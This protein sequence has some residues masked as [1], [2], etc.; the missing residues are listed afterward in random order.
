MR[1]PSGVAGFDDLI[2]GGLPAGRLYVL[3]GPPGSGK[4]TFSSQFLVEGVRQG[5]NC[6]LVSMHESRGDIVEDM[7]GYDFGFEQAI[8][9]DRMHFVDVF[10]NE[11]KQ[12]FRLPGNRRGGNDVVN[13]LT[14]FIESKNI[15][16]VVIDSTM[17]LEYF[18]DDTENS[19]IQFLTALKRTDA[20]TI[21]VSEMT[22]PSAYADEHYLAH[23]VVF[24]H[25]FLEDDGMQR[26]IQVLKMRGTAI[27][28]DI[29]QVSFGDDGLRVGGPQ[30][31]RH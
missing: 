21:L 26:G 30:L 17:L 1:V 6:L 25:N 16:R 7:S 24:L 3:C 22:D 19:V 15:E 31:Q 2:E 9:T 28:A 14:G 20:T 10:S 13:R 4:T 5:D 11:G 12:L 8:R 29:H 18:L 23:G 27:D